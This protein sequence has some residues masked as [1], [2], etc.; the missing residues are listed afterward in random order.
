MITITIKQAFYFFRHNIVLLLG[1]A[2]L[3]AIIVVLLARLLSPLFIGDINSE[4]INPDTI[5]PL[6]QFLN[7]I[8]KPVYTG[9]LIA[10]IF[11]LATGQGR[12]IY[13][14][15]WQGILRWPYM[16]MANV[17]TSLLIFA[18][19]MLFILPGIWLF[20]RLFLVPYLVMID[21]QT[22]LNA[23]IN[24]FNYT[25][26]YAL[27]LFNDIVILVVIFILLLWLLGSLQ[28]LHPL[29]LL[30]LILVFQSMANVLYYRHYEILVREPRQAQDKSQDPGNSLDK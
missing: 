13:S 25:K 7:L 23:I 24:S 1:F 9:G 3:I 10:L 22:P 18:G 2:L 6:A 19:L 14:S 16:F 5:R 21:R 20:T 15:L 27:T 28:L 11:S 30:V 26:G 8:I 4:Q 17:M 29:V 12:G